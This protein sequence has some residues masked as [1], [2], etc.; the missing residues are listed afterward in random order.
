MFLFLI[1]SSYN[2]FQ[3]PLPFL[4]MFTSPMKIHE[5]YGPGIPK[6][7]QKHPWVILRNPWVLLNIFL[8]GCFPCNLP[9]QTPVVLWFPSTQAASPS[10]LALFL[11]QGSPKW[12][13]T[14]SHAALILNSSDS[15]RN[16]QLMVTCWFGAR[17]CGILRVTLSN[18]PFTKNIQS[19]SKPP[20][21]PNHQFTI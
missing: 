18:N 6:F 14:R 17:S 12:S 5:L 9:K 8:L 11:T 19:E 10:R 15:I 21:N 13:L 1:F 7:I 20:T 4:M 2:T 3:K 16:G